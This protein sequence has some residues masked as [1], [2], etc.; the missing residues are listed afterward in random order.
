MYISYIYHYVTQLLQ[1]C[2]LFYLYN[3]KEINIFPSCRQ[4]FA[5]PAFWLNWACRYSLLPKLGLQAR[6]LRQRKSAKISIRAQD[7]RRK[8]VPLK[9]AG[10]SMMMVPL[11]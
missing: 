10:P 1:Y 2:F 3:L 5:L 11:Y 8:Q 9:K 7:E 6:A 4:Q